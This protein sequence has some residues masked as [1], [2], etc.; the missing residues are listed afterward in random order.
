MTMIIIENI[1]V[2]SLRR[3]TTVISLLEYGLTRIIAV[4]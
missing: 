4:K 1:A 3:M 2:A